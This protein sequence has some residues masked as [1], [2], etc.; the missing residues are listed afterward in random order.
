MQLRATSASETSTP[1]IIATACPALKVGGPHCKGYGN[2]I[3]IKVTSYIIFFYVRSLRCLVSMKRAGNKIIPIT[4]D[5]YR[6]LLM[7]V[8]SRTNMT[9][10]KSVLFY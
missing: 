1:A 4:R 2:L 6:N 5:G 8:I 3:L 9:S 10:E 7:S